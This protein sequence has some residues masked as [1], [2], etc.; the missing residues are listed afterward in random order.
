MSKSANE[1]RFLRSDPAHRELRVRLQEM[2]E[3]YA[4]VLDEEEYESWPAFFEDECTYKITSSENFNLDLPIAAMFCD[5]INMV[6]DRVLALRETT[7]YEPRALRHMLGPIRIKSVDGEKV[8]CVT[9]YVVFESVLET[10]PRIFSVGRYIDTVIDSDDA[11]K[12]RKRLCV[13]D[14]YRIYNSLISPI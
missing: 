3:D 7:V 4:M 14:N 8:E 10:D 9:N 6:R 1:N 11:L 5:G 2:F 12:F 13:Y